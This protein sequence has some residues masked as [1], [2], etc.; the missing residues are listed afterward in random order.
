MRGVPWRGTEGALDDRGDLIIIDRS[1]SA[2]TSFVQQALDAV[3]QKASTP[4]SDCVLVEAEFARDG[5]ARDAI[6]ASQDDAAAFRQRP[7]HAMAANLP[8]KI[9][10]LIRIQDQRSHRAPRRIR[11]NLAPT[12]CESG[13]YNE[14]NF[15]SR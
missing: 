10:P 8:L 13:S 14:M 2:G 7:R 11:H 12:H 6:R 9:G 4:L 15:S 1:R 5:F 3:L